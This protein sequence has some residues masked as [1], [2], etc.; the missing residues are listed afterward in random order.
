MQGEATA[1]SRAEGRPATKAV[2]GKNR[3]IEQQEG[4]ARETKIRRRTPRGRGA[5]ETRNLQKR[6][7]RQGLGGEAE[8][9]RQTG[10]RSR[11]GKQAR[12]KG[13]QRKEVKAANAKERRSLILRRE[14]RLAP[15]S[16]GPSTW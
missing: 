13:G 8:T 2:T 5:D 4:D 3:A 16:P 12:Q 11:G 7:K 15:G 14:R 10:S 9:G 6:Q 1:N